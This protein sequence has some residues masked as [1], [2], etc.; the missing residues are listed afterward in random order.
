MKIDYGKQ[1][2][3]NFAKLRSSEQ[4]RVF[5]T[6]EKFITNPNTKSLRKHALTGEWKG[7]FSISV[8]GDLRIHYEVIEKDQVEFITIGTHAQLYK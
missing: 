1:F 8:G 4:K 7:C 5:A 6:V 3:K 2:N